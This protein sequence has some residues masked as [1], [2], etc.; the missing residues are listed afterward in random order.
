MPKYFMY[1]TSLEGI[2][3]LIILPPNFLPKRS[4]I[5]INNYFSCERGFKDCNCIV[6]DVR[7]RYNPDYCLCFKEILT[8]DEIEYRNLIKDY[9]MVVKI[10]REDNILNYK[11]QI[12][13]IK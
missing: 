7:D 8:T 1:G 13:Q 11:E 3:Q 2:E 9:A 6:N 5:V 4:C 10:T 12:L